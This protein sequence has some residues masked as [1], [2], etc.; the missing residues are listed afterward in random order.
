MDGGV[1]DLVGRWI[2]D[3]LW[4]DAGRGRQDGV[5]GISLCPVIPGVFPRSNEINEIKFSPSVACTH[6]RV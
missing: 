4:W 6:G 2:A 3:G 5:P 1:G